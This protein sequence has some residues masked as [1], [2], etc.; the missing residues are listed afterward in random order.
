MKRFGWVMTLLICAA[1]FVMRHSSTPS[2]PMPTHYVSQGSHIQV[3]AVM[4][5]P[6]ATQE[7]WMLSRRAGG[8]Y[9]VTVFDH[10]RMARQFASVKLVRHTAQ[11][12][13]YSTG[14][15]ILLDGIRYRALTIHIEP[16]GTAGDITLISTGVS[17]GQSANG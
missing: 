6:L 15:T 4:S 1:F 7:F 9:Y 11:G 2:V 5:L 16:S 12:T 3:P 14:G 13:F 8:P 17:A 10:G